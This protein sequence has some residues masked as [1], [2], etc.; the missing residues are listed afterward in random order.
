MLGVEQTM[1]HLQTCACAPIHTHGHV[2][3]SMCVHKHRQSAN[4]K[5]T[6]VNILT[7]CLQADRLTLSVTNV[8]LKLKKQALS[9]SP[10]CLTII[11]LHHKEKI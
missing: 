11:H 1:A 10:G 4:C 6:D 8:E 9:V 7:V 2:H 3:F 5:H